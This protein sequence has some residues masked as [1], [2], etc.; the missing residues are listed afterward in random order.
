MTLPTVR[1]EVGLA[2]PDIGAVFVIGDPLRGR[3]GVDAIGGEVWTDI[4]PY[5]RNW[6]VR[7]GASEGNAPTRRYGPG[8]ATITLNDGDRRFDP[9]NLAG[10][11]VSA[12]LTQILPM[13]RVRITGEWAGVAYPIWQGFADDWVPEYVGND[14]T[15]CTLTATDA[16]KVWAT[17]K[18]PGAASGGGG[19]TTGARITRIL[20]SVSWPIE[21]RVIDPGITTVQVT[22]LSGQALAELQL[23]Q[24][25]EL[26]EFFVDQLG[27]A[28]FQDR[29]S[30]LN[31]AAS[32]ASQ[33]TFGDA[34]YVPTPSYD[35]E[36]GIT[37]FTTTS[38]ASVAT[39][40]T[41]FNGTGALELTVVG[42]PVQAY[43]RAARFPVTPG[44][45][46]QVTMW[47]RRPVAG[48]VVC[49]IDW[50]D[51]GGTYLSGGTYPVTALSAGVWTQITDTATAPAG[52]ATMTW[53]PT[54]SGSPATGTLLQLDDVLLT[55][56]DNE[57]PYADVA[58]TSPDETMANRVSITR[59]GGAVQTA[60]DL[61]AQ[62]RFLIKDFD[63]SDLT[64]QTDAVAL[65]YAKQ[66]LFRYKDPTRR[67]A[68]L[69]FLTPTPQDEG[70]IWPQRLGRYFGDRITVVRRPA[71]GGD[72]ITGDCFIRGF[73]H[74]SNGES[75]TSAFVL[76]AADKSSYFTI[77]HPTRGRVGVTPIAF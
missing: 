2:G 32:A 26:G 69:M 3:V 7:L 34:G 16:T 27:R 40:A 12:G 14:W 74:E 8:T 50:Q 65:N 57:L 41:A 54:L 75:W 45:R 21:D 60:E 42:S 62:A 44:H 25:T 4:T 22:D 28:V 51:A 6:S 30:V 43:V 35:F 59:V 29:Q 13:V 48:N 46:Y 31:R 53:G 33:A 36:D 71:G 38:N 10:P 23:T 1:V 39:T 47:V 52:A 68:R 49:A 70:V 58:R 19:E 56:L 9:D 37:G 61:A 76:E 20:N 5:V 72:P 24:D 17:E 63:R 15:Y 55:D 73:E 67:F 18:R 11:Y 66:V 77:G 64:M